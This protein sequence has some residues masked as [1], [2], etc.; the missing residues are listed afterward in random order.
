[1]KV[2][3]RLGDLVGSQF[4]VNDEDPKFTHAL[5]NCLAQWGFSGSS[6]A[7]HEHLPGL[8]LGEPGYEDRI[9]G[10]VPA[11]GGVDADVAE[12]LIAAGADVNAKDGTGS[13]ALDTAEKAAAELLRKHGGKTA[14]ELKAAGK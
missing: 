8:V 2:P 12:L 7:N 6:H 14:E 9:V 5:F 4:L 10:P 11:R 3:Q 13:T 1:V